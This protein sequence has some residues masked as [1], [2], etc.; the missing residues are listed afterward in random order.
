M[1]AHCLIIIVTN[2]LIVWGFGDGHRVSENHCGI[3]IAAK[4]SFLFGFDFAF[5]SLPKAVQ[6][7]K[8]PK[9]DNWVSFN[10]MRLLYSFE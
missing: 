10:Q 3:I 7:S 4:R 2:V 9:R 1:A 6:T 5:C 8:R